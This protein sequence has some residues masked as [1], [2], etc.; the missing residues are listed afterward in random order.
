MTVSS[1]ETHNTSVH[2]SVHTHNMCAL[3]MYT[4]IQRYY[5]IRRC[6]SCLLMIWYCLDVKLSYSY[7]SIV[8]IDQFSSLSESSD[9]KLELTRHI[10]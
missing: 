3:I 8:N 7:Q 9:S 1:G 2:L 6:M 4:G 5:A 10:M